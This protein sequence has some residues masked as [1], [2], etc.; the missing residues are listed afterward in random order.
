MSLILD[1]LRKMEQDRN[2]RRGAAANLRPEVLRYRGASKP[3]RDM[4]YLPVALGLA[5]LACGVGGGF[6]LKGNRAVV[7]SQDVAPPLSATAALPVAPATPVAPAA[8][9]TPVA[10]DQPAVPAVPGAVAAPQAGQRTV[11]APLVRSVGAHPVRQSAA[12]ARKERPAPD[13]AAQLQPVYREAAAAPLPA[14]ADISITGI[15]WQDERRLRRAV[16]NGTL[17]GEGAEVAGARVVEIR[18]DRVRLSRGGQLFDAVF[19]TGFSR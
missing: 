2:S 4:R 10:Q 17:V 7:V 19:S 8:P 15:A 3:K 14:P 9:A 6:F 1:A 12:G 13:R 16:V 18:E 5:L 11:S